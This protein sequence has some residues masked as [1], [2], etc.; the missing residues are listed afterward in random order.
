MSF[1]NS[2]IWTI[3]T[4]LYFTVLVAV[5]SA[6]K[7]KDE[8]LD[9][10][11]GYFLAGNG[12]PGIVI[13]G[14]LLLTNL[15]AEQLVG[16][17]GQ[18]WAANMSP[19]AFEVGSLFTLFV[20]AYVFLP[21]YLRMGVTTM[22]ELIEARFDRTTRTIFAIIICV[23]YALLNLPVILYSGAVVFESIFSISESI[24]CSRFMA[25][26]LICVI[27]GIVGGCYAIFGGLKAV[28]V[29]DTINGIGLLIGGLMI[30]FLALALLGKETSGGGIIDGFM[31]MVKTNPAKLNAW[32]A[33]DAREPEL[34][35]PLI[36]TG[37]FFFNFFA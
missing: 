17:N 11:S 4:F 27:I 32:S 2:T 35:W 36:F 6:W 10:A 7:T 21:T 3:I 1:F 33:W 20:L 23:M 13:A 9:T 29:S 30:L 22:P 24:G 37:M 12:L 5:I 8:Q 15:S 28:A 18:G 25:V 34:P 31:Y 14:S 19:I 16:T 26:A